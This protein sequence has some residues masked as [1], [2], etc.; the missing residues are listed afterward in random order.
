LS[1]NARAKAAFDLEQKKAER[2]LVPAASG[3]VHG[4]A[5]TM[6]LFSPISLLRMKN[7][8]LFWRVFGLPAVNNGRLPVE[9]SIKPPKNV[10]IKVF[11]HISARPRGADKRPSHRNRRTRSSNREDKALE[12]KNA[13]HLVNPH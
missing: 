3:L 1:I 7:M 13:E 9:N 2:L 10:K 8:A 6:T 5:V 4:L 11:G 12:R